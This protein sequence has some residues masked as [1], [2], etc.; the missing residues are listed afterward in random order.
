M[1]DRG[2][3]EGALSAT[4]VQMLDGEHVQ[5]VCYTYENHSSQSGKSSIKIVDRSSHAIAYV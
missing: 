2:K 3:P 5:G 4:M 1:V